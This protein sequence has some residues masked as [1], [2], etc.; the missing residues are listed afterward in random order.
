MIFSENRISLFGDHALVA[1][2][3]LHFVEREILTGDRKGMSRALLN[4]AG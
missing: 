3:P 1:H 2:H 4:S